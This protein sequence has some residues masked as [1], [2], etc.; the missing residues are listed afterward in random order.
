VKIAVAGKGGAGKTFVAAGFARLYA[1]MGYQVY[2]V[3]AEP[4]GSLGPELG[5]SRHEIDA[6]RPIMVMREFIDDRRGDGALY[7]MNPNVGGAADQ[8]SADAGGVRFLKM[9]DI[10]PAGSSC[11]CE[12]HGFLLALMNSLLLGERDVVILDM[13]AGVEHLARGTC[14]GADLMLVVTEATRAGVEMARAIRALSAGL[15]IGQVLVVAN[16]IHSE[17]EEL[18][19]R[20]NF[21]RV[22]LLGLLH[23]SKEAADRAIGIG[24]RGS[25]GD[26][27]MPEFEA[28]YERLTSK[29]AT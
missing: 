27:W 19:I 7:L 9:A 17:K 1:G 25:A 14:R 6:V 4:G 12:E 23:E 28:L 13:G 8:F 5:L 26:P 20:A 24:G 11:Y 18:F 10:K 3:D 15:G 29:E 16:K 2:A 21:H 22:E